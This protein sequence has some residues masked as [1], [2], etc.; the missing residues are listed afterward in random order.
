MGEVIASAPGR[1]CLFGEHQDYLGLP[2]IAAAVDLRI[3]GRAVPVSGREYVVQ[4]PDTGEE[5]CLD[6]TSEQVYGQQRD[7]LASSINVLR[8][9]GWSPAGGWRVTIRSTIPINAGVSSSSAMVVMWLRLLAGIGE[10]IELHADSALATLAHE[11]EVVEFAEPGGMMDHFCA[12]MGGALAVNTLPPFSALRL[13]VRPDGFV[14]GHSL[15]PKATL[16]TLRARRAD[17]VQ[18]LDTIRSRIPEFDLATTSLCDA[19][20]QLR[21]AGDVPAR[22]LRAQMR[23][24]DIASAAR[25]MLEAGEI[26]RLG[27]LLSEHHHELRD[28]LDLSTPRLERMIDGSLAAGALGAKVN[29]SG[30][31]GCM[32]AYA[33]G[34]EEAVCAAIESSGG[35]AYRVCVGEGATLSQSPPR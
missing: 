1:I 2:V 10:G 9:R 18:G 4:M 5:R 15:E 34:R 13:P 30:G 6:P 3:E 16:E 22:R 35:R 14:L 31:G 8:R 11:A 26:G 29:G 19:E 25:T 20:P 24:R 33:P 23:N 28:G 27:P 21:A 17:V 12:A 7:Y 32:F